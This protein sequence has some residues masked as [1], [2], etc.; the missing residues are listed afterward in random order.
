MSRWLIAL[1]VVVVSRPVVADAADAATGFVLEQAHRKVTTS[2]S[3]VAPSSAEPSLAT[4][5]LADHLLAVER[6]GMLDVVDTRTGRTVAS[7]PLALGGIQSVCRPHRG[8]LL[9]KTH[10]DLVSIDRTTGDIRW[11]QPA[12]SHGNAIVAPRGDRTE[13]VDAWVDRETHRYGLVSRDPRTGREL[14][15]IDLGSTSGWYDI[16]SVQLAPDGPGDVLVS[17]LFGVD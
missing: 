16:E 5:P 15:R 1:A 6:P 12:T 11:V 8:D 13:V 7:T 9:V 14:A 2:S 4:V 17:A 10:G 3:V